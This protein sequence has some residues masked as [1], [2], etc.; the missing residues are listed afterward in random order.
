MP[1]E[2]DHGVFA[3]LKT[4]SLSAGP[5]LLNYFIKIGQGKEAFKYEKYVITVS[6]C[7]LKILE[8][9][10]Q[11]QWFF[12]T[13]LIG[14]K[15]RSMLTAAIYR[16]H[17]RLLNVAKRKYSCGE[18]INHVTVDAYRIGEFLIW[19]HQT[20]TT[21]LQLCLALIILIHP[22]KLATMESLVVIVL[23]VICKAPTT[24]LQHKFQSKLMAA[25]DGRLKA[26]SE[27]LMSMKV[28]VSGSIS[29]VSQIAWIQTGT[30]RENI[31]F[32]SAMDDLRYRETLHRCSLVKDLELFPCGDMTETGEKGVNLS[33]GQKQRIQLARV[34]YQNAD[35]Y[36][37]NDPFSVV[38]AHT[39]TSLFNEY[40]MEALSEKIV[41]LV[42][43]QV[44][45]LP[46]FHCCLVSVPSFNR[47]L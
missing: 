43:H 42:T 46:A 34:L 20:W 5:L 13:R 23:T 44:D 36:L 33:G 11:R 8:S 28:E 1:L 37:L 10:S 4:L 35:I 22:I 17:L 16:K 30:I 6:L 27:A 31:L 41:L 7:L 18:I 3:F 2:G 14:L 47:G 24:K 25:Q 32:T 12:R 45:F 26:C 21:S 40:V 19:F 39:A 9:L 29:Y 38:D 15:V